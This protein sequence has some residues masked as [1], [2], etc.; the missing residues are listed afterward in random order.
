MPDT[1]Y[2]RYDQARQQPGTQ[3]KHSARKRSAQDRAPDAEREEDLSP[4]RPPG[5]GVRNI[6]PDCDHSAADEGVHGIAA[7]PLKRPVDHPHRK[8][9]DEQRRKAVPCEPCAQPIRPQCQ[10]HSAKGQRL[11]PGRAVIDQPRED[12]PGNKDP[13]NQS[14]LQVEVLLRRILPVNKQSVSIADRSRS[15]RNGLGSLARLPSPPRPCLLHSRICPQLPA[16]PAKN[17]HFD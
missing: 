10:G 15:T 7:A 11:A 6:R 13:C 9:E 8:G 1:A 17:Q 12:G 16:A 4:V 14:V 5:Q 3:R 2:C